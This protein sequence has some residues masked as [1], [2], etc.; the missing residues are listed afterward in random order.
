MSPKKVGKQEQ[1]IHSQGREII[2]NVAAFMKKEAEQGIT[3]PLKNVRQRTL[4][5]TRVSQSTYRRVVQESEDIE[6]IPSCSFTSPRKK[7]LRKSQKIGNI[8]LTQIK[9]IKQIVYDFYIVE[10]RRPTLK[11]S[12]SGEY[13][14]DMNHHNFM[15]WAE[16]QLIPNLLPNSVLVLDVLMCL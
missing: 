1:I 15:T 16:N 8:T 14:D 6:N 11:W 3:I 12:K 7:R 5:A 9:D 2:S 4:A 10:K 13:H